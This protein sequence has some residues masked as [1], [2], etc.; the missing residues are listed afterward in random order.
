LG[1]ECGRTGLHCDAED[2]QARNNENLFH[3]I[4][5]TRK[6]VQLFVFLEQLQILEPAPDM[7]HTGV[8]V[9]WSSCH[10][11]VQ[12][13]PVHMHVPLQCVR[14]TGGFVLTIGAVVS[15]GLVFIWAANAN[16]GGC[17][18]KPE[19]AKQATMKSCFIQSSTR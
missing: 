5:P 2:N 1:C 6:T 12:S 18:T 19:T 10:F 14:T 15:P 13:S 3:S 11:C 17:M 16:D 4:L 8:S 9:Q 7:L